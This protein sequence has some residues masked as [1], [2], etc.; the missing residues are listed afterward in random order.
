MADRTHR[1]MSDK[2]GRT[3]GY[4]PDEKKR[5]KAETEAAVRER[6]EGTDL[7]AAARAEGKRRG[8]TVAE[9]AEGRPTRPDTA[10][11]DLGEAA[12]ANKKYKAE[13]AAW[14]KRQK[15]PAA[16]GQ[17]KALRKM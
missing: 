14:E 10:G 8:M 17:K 4:K 3:S 15:D 7:G 12:A 5:E 6:M 11:M 16:K 2:R 1:R 9:P 13:L